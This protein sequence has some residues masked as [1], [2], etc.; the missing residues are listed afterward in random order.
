[1]NPADTDSD[2]ETASGS[3]Q[4]AI[5]SQGILLEQHDQILCSLTESN[6]AMVNQ[7]ALVTNQVTALTSQ[8]RQS[9]PAHPAHPDPPPQPSQPVSL[10][11]GPSSLPPCYVA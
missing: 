4:K 5:T 8:L 9:V 10:A 1:M 6:Q 2:T 7:I 3:V 11:Q